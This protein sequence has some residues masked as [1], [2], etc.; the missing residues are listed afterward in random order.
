MI[1]TYLIHS[2]LELKYRQS[3]V[4]MADQ[5]M[6]EQAASFLRRRPKTRYLVAPPARSPPRAVVAEGGLA[7]ALRPGA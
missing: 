7:P 2:A 6:E 4:T 3:R 1:E 5:I